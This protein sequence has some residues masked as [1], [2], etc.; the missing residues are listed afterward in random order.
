MSC[1]SL[2]NNAIVISLYLVAELWPLVASGSGT[3]LQ[4][5]LPWGQ[6]CLVSNLWLSCSGCNQ[7]GA[8]GFLCA[9]SMLS[10]VVTKKGHP[11][12]HCHPLKPIQ[13]LPKETAFGNFR[14]RINKKRMEEGAGELGTAMPELCQAA[15]T[16]M[17]SALPP[18]FRFFNL[19]MMLKIP[20]GACQRPEDG[21]KDEDE[22]NG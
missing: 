20:T 2:S 17:R 3:G 21:R 4:A 6:L 12:T 8:V 22:L 15:V 13:N 11:F 10:V 7:Q 19:D 5:V 18:P 14:M 9:A 1:S 16:S